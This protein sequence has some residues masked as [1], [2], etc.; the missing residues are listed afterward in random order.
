M[1]I[2]LKETFVPAHA[3]DVIGQCAFKLSARERAIFVDGAPII[4]AQELASPIAI[5]QHALHDNAIAGSH[6]RID[7]KRREPPALGIA[8]EQHGK[9]MPVLPAA[10]GNALSAWARADD[11]DADAAHAMV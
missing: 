2:E 7:G 6:R 3:A 1:R 11:G 5:G 4:F 10:C 8:L 9:F